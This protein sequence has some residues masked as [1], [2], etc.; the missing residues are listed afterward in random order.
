MFFFGFS[1]EGGL[2]LGM[3]FYQVFVWL[4]RL[5]KDGLRG[6]RLAIRA[7]L[8]GVGGGGRCR[9]QEGLGCGARSA[10]GQDP[11]LL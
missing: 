3:E 11:A 10:H 6:Y 4:F 7:V 1:V 9:V 5:C 2:G 8:Q